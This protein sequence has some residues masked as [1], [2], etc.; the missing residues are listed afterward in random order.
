[1]KSG[2]LVFLAAFVALAASWAGLVLAPQL[3][4]G[5]SQQTKTLGGE[6]YPQSRPGLARQGLEVYRA[7]GCMYCHTQQVRQEGA[8]CEI[9]LTEPGTNANATVMALVR[10]NPEL[11]KLSPV[12]LLGG[13]PKTVAT[14][15]DMNAAEPALR[16]LEALGAKAEVLVSAVG[17]DIARGWGLRRTVALDYLTDDPVQPGSRRI[18]P[19]LANV[20]LR[21]PDAQWHLRHLYAPR[22]EVKDSTMPPYR[23]LFETRK[24]GARPSP[25][26]L[27]LP[28]EFAPPA[29]YE[30]VPKPEAVALVAYLLSLRADAPLFEM[31]VMT[32][33]APAPATNAPATTASSK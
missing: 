4:L 12:V 3:Q 18:G 13:L 22:S 29:G 11:G 23:F 17:P 9:V 20:G 21:L 8:R 28:P 5:L 25:D 31:P 19:D 33:P 27:H 15:P 24:I 30:V 6:P 10:L 16:A 14:V 7:Q 2:A 1:M 26:A 32:L